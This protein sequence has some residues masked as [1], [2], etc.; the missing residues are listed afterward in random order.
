MSPEQRTSRYYSYE[1]E[2]YSLGLIL[3]EMLRFF[4][5]TTMRNKAFA[6]INEK[7]VVNKLIPNQPEIASLI[8]S[9]TRFSPQNR[10][11][12]ED[13]L[14]VIEREIEKIQLG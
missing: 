8:L 9:M 12:L 11:T 7:K 4:K 2:I 6:L 13:A 5:T 1:A 10:P 3:I 14:K